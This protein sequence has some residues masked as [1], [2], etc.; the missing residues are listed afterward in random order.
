LYEE[1][2]REILES[3]SRL[4]RSFWQA[5]MCSLYSSDD[6]DDDDD[7]FP[8]NDMVDSDVEE[9]SGGSENDVT[10]PQSV[11]HQDGT[12]D[13]ETTAGMKKKFS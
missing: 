1:A 5:K 7:V 11:A 4:H 2:E 9:D 13:K 10:N 6:E 3:E 12:C 8:E